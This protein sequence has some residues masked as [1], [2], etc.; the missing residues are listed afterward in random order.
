VNGNSDV[1]SDA[2]AWWNIT[3]VNLV[4]M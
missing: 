3:W 4:L 1:S 2:I